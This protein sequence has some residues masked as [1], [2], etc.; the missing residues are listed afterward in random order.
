[1]SNG[2]ESPLLDGFYQLVATRI[3]KQPNRESAQRRRRV[4]EEGPG[5]D[6][7]LER[8]RDPSGLKDYLI[9]K[10]HVQSALQI[11]RTTGKMAEIMAKAFDA[12][13]TIE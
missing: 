12:A 6:A 11:L 4:L 1:M 8:L 10:H 9:A 5:R 13:V 3:T 2:H 7:I